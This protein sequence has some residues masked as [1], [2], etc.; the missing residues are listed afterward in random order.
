MVERDADPHHRT[1][2]EGTEGEL[3]D[4]AEVAAAA[5]QRP[6]QVGVLRRRRGHDL[7]GSQHD[8]ELGKIVTGEPVLAGEPADAAAER[9]AGDARLG[10]DP[11]G[12]DHA[13]RPGGRVHIT[14]PAAAAGV[15]QVLLGVD[16]HLP[17]SAEVDGQ[18]AI[19]Q[20]LAGDVVTA[21]PHRRRQP[22]VA[23]GI[24]RGHDV[25]RA[26]T[27]QDQART[28]VDHRV[29]DGPGLLVV[30]AV[31]LDDRAAEPALQ[32]LNDLLP[33]RG[34]DDAIRRVS[35][36]GSHGCFAFFRTGVARCDG[37]RAR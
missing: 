19:G 3:R 23:G 14:E 35:G 1:E 5:P 12:H 34:V 13:E 17:Q 22:E 11:G 27:G 28:L 4:D 7:A 21:A 20:R 30:R 10:H 15:R 31:R 32:G 33:S 2:V 37:A 25:R 16:G 36:G 9:K 8:L 24:D 18:P 26:G 29:P 6:E